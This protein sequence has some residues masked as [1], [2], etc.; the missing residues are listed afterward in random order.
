MMLAATTRRTPARRHPM[1]AIL[2]FNLPSPI[3]TPLR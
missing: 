1:L 2:I 3:H